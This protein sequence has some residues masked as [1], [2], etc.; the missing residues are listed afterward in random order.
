MKKVKK[1]IK[2]E[3]K[4]IIDAPQNKGVWN[5]RVI[6]FTP[7]TGLVRTEWVA[8]RY[9]QII[10]CNWS[11]VEMQQYISAYMPNQYQLADAQNLLAKKI[12]EDDYE[13]TI[14]IEH[15][16]IIPPDLFMK[17]NQYMKEKKVPMVSGLYFTKTEPAEPILYRGRGNSCYEDWK[18]G[19]KVWVDGVPFGC[20]LLH[21]S[22]IKAAWEESPEYV[23]NGITTRRVFETP[24]RVWFDPE[25]GGMV[26]KRGTTDLAWCTRL[27]EEGLF[28]KA[29]WG[30]Y[31]KKKNPFLVDTTIFVKHIDQNGRQYPLQM[32]KKFIK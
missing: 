13:W 31:Q 5:N 9:G 4:L 1:K 7:T 19:D 11:M 21:N 3:K 30:E 26:A 28:E 10:P 32:P 27:M 24:N 6:L 25:K 23:I 2:K 16:N 8:S 29:G 15:D 18:L 20:L 17:F 12:V 22:L 14:F